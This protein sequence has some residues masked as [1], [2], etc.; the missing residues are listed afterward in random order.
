MKRVLMTT[1]C[2]LLGAT[3]CRGP[4]RCPCLQHRL[5]ELPTK[6]LVPA[7]PTV[8]LANLK[9]VPVGGHTTFRVF[10]HLFP[11][12]TNSSAAVVEPIFSTQTVLR[13]W[14]YHHLPTTN[15]DYCAYF[16]QDISPHAASSLM[17]GWVEIPIIGEQANIVIFGVNLPH[18]DMAFNGTVYVSGGHINVRQTGA[19][20]QEPSHSSGR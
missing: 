19:Q 17:D 3:G 15:L 2:L 10:Y 13:I 18:K 1:V 14:A 8:V 7:A 16:T 9:N 5:Y 20:A 11:V 12:C 6:R 4:H